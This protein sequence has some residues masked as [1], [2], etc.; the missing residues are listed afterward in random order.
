M[1]ARETRRPPAAREAREAPARRDALQK[2]ELDALKAKLE[3][4]EDAVMNDKSLTAAKKHRMIA[5]VR[6]D[7]ASQRRA[8]KDHVAAPDK[9]VPQPGAVA[10]H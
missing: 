2:S 10:A 1:E 7:F 4:A 6:E 8:V 9:P 5:E 3:A